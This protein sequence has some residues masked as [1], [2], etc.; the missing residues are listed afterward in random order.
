MAAAIPEG[1]TLDTATA[2]EQELWDTTVAE[3]RLRLSR[4][5]HSTAGRKAE[6]V[7]RILYTTDWSPL[8][9]NLDGGFDAAEDREQALAENAVA[10]SVG[11]VAIGLSAWIALASAFYTK[12]YSCEFRGRL[13]CLPSGTFDGTLREASVD[14]VPSTNRDTRRKFVLHH[15]YRAQHWVRAQAIILLS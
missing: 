6:L 2:L 15:R 12:H 14:G 1:A 13:A 7:D 8:D 11:K 3:L 5:G 4:A 9:R 10:E